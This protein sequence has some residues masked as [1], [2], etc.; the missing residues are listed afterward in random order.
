VLGFLS[1]VAYQGAQNGIDPL[2]GVDAKGVAAWLDAHCRSHPR[3]KLV[4]AAEA[5][6]QEHTHR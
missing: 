4:H 2:R 6:V 1:G 3:Q 5:F